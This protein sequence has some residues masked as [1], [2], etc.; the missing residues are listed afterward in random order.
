M[1]RVAIYAR[2][3]CTTPEPRG[4]EGLPLQREPCKQ[5]VVTQAHL[6][7]TFDSADYY[8]DEGVSGL[9][10]ERPALQRMLAEVDAGAIHVVVAHRLDRVSR[11]IGQVEAVAERVLRAGAT[12][13]VLAA[14]GMGGV[15]VTA[16]LVRIQR[17]LMTETER[18]RS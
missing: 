11:D 15:N 2:S 4:E 18:S 3:A 13:I 5:Y 14:G 16:T 1:K 6:G 12:L 9:T 7:W 8:E 10:L 17:H